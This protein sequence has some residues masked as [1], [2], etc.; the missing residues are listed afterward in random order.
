MLNLQ[1][2]CDEP[3][4][5]RRTVKTGANPNQGEEKLKP[6]PT[7]INYERTELGEYANKHNTDKKQQNK[8]KLDTKDE[9][10]TNSG[11]YNPHQP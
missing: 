7:Q 4:N 6:L 5:Q 10:M 11:A 3:Q 1:D 8:R 2:E 9:A